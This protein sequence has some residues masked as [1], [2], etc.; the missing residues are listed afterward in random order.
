MMEKRSDAME[1]S[2]GCVM[3]CSFC[4]IRCMYGKSFRKYSDERVITD[5][6]NCKRNGKQSLLV[7]DD[8]ITLDVRRLMN[9]CDL[10]VE[11]KL[12]DICYII[13]ASS[14]GIASTPDLAKKMR[15]A[16]FDYCFLG[17][18]N[19]SKKNLDYLSKG[20]ETLE[21]TKRAV[22]YLRENKIGTVGG[23][24]LGNPEDD[25][26][27]FEENF[28]FSKELKV[29]GP[30]YF[31]TTPHYGTELR[32]EMLE[33]GL[34]T[35]VEDFSWYNGSYANIK[36]KYLSSDDIDRIVQKM[37]GRYVD[38]NSFIYGIVWKRHKLFFLKK[39]LK[40]GSL[41]VIRSI[42]RLFREQK[43]LLIEAR[44]RDVIRR[45][46]WFLDTDK[47][48]IERLKKKNSKAG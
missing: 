46:R 48:R 42:R 45:A 31:I 10:I 44:E 33:K 11:N 30:L 17:I 39:S 1:T 36:T 23:F 22:A 26:E 19:A 3:R 28:K 15:K 37:Y 43:D 13:Q 41:Q 25:E 6:K 16:G 27:V 21:E 2:R 4:S 35:N 7:V 9:L 8:N 5:I 18:E 40:E 14:K 38:I 24:V 32:D 34:V 47:D 29:D 20:E 12:N